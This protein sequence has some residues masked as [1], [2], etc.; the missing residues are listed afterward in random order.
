MTTAREL[1]T[2]DPVS[3]RDT[4]TLLVAARTMRDLGRSSAP[5]V[6]RGSPPHRRPHRPRHRG[7]LRGRGC[8]PGG[9]DG[10]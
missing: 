5:G 1:M 8:R 9:D 2:V 3:I 4:D 6:R 7:R 10:R